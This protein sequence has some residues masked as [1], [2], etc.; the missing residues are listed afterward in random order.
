MSKMLKASNDHNNTSRC[1]PT[2]SNRYF[3]Y[4]LIINKK[5]IRRSGS[6]RNRLSK[7]KKTKISVFEKPKNGI[8]Y[9]NNDWMDYKTRFKKY[10]NESKLG[11]VVT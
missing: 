6:V 10:L 2:H 8:R 5:K 1:L 4:Y 3:I 11:G 9:F 7:N